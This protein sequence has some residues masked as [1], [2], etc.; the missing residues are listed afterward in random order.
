MISDRSDLLFLHPLLF[1][2][3]LRGWDAYHHNRQCY[4]DHNTTTI[5]GTLSPQ[6]T[7]AV[8]I[9]GHGTFRLGVD[10]LTCGEVAFPPPTAPPKVSCL[11]VCQETVWVLAEVLR[12]L[13]C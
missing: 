12:R 10:L 2:F 9:H 7:T 1:C 4:N 13:V 3:S 11:C 6:T 8:A 5:D